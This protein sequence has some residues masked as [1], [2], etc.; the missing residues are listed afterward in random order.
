MPAN[1]QPQLSSCEHFISLDRSCTK[2]ARQVRPRRAF[3]VIRITDE[4][5]NKRIPDVAAV[6]KS[7]Q[8]EAEED[9]R[10]VTL[11]NGEQFLCPTDDDAQD[12][13]KAHGSDGVIDTIDVHRVPYALCG[14][15][16]YRA[17]SYG[18]WMEWPQGMPEE[19]ESEELDSDTD[20]SFDVDTFLAEVLPARVPLILADRN[21]T[22]LYQKSINEV[23]AYRGIGKTLYLYQLIKLLT[24][25]GTWLRYLSSGGKRVLLVD[26]ELPAEQLQQRIRE[27]VGPTEGLLRIISP[28]RLP[29]NTLPALSDKAAQDWLLSQIAMTEPDVIVFDTLTAC[30]RF[31]TNDPDSWLAV[32]QFL[33][34]LR[35]QGLCVLLAHHAGK[36]GTQRGR[37][38]AEDNC[39]LVVKL[40]APQGWQP[41]D[42]ADFHV[43]YDKVRAGDR[44]TPFRA[45]LDKIT[46][47]P[48]VLVAVP[49]YRWTEYIDPEI[50]KVKQALVAGKSVRTVAAETGVAKST[51]DRIAQRMKREQA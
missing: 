28:E 6:L 46:P 4:E 23:F 14:E 31:D 33:I 37:T 42:G 8:R 40:E 12:T 48:G 1:S 34:R 51:V 19:S 39:D 7:L 50:A 17:K 24:K 29:H 41:G 21:A 43:Q 22:L 16:R 5:F 47:E 45:K 49:C 2:C 10:V 35:M 15:W 13:L 32:N 38:D 26:G 3:P 18:A 30:F 27:Q 9:A 36:N 44:L 20:Y 25:G 11:A